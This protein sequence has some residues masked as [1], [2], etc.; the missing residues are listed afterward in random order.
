VLAQGF[1]PECGDTS[2]SGT[3]GAS[4]SV[5]AVSGNT[6]SC[7]ATSSSSITWESDNTAVAT[8]DPTNTTSSQT[9]QL[10][11]VGS[12]NILA[13][14]S[15]GGSGMF[16]GFF[17]VTVN[18]A[19]VLVVGSQASPGPCTPVTTVPATVNN[20]VQVTA[21]TFD[22]TNCTPVSVSWTSSEPGICTA[23]PGPSVT[24]TV[25]PLFAGSSELTAT[26]ASFSAQAQVN[27]Q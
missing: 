4:L 23:D 11:G 27:V 22:G 26:G 15:L 5:A 8:I 19:Q 9:V 16:H 18:P 17:P 6:T 24:T 25:H 20:P 14:A 7:S 13:S 1:L 3:I 21:A 10:V 2:G 12:A